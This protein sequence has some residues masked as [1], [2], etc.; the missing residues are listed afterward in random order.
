MRENK[1]NLSEQINRTHNF[2]E[3]SKDN[4]NLKDSAAPAS[5]QI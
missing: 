2:S 1:E 4:Q 3:E 5:S